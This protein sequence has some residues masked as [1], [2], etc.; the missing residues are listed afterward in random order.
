MLLN[1]SY[2]QQIEALKWEP[3]DKVVAD[4]DDHHIVIEASRYQTMSF[5]IPKLRVVEA[6][7]E[8]LPGRKVYQ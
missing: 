3:H 6:K 4:T 5:K 7:G 1:F 8:L 2:V